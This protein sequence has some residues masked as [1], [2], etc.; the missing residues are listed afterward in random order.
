MAEILVLDATILFP[1]REILV[2][3]ATI[4]LKAIPGFRTSF[5]RSM[6]FEGDGKA[7]RQGGIPGDLTLKDQVS[8]M[9]L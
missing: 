9:N 4:L 3:D 5:Q 7:Y 2:M 8:K 6:S 1:V